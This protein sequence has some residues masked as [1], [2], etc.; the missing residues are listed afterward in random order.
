MTLYNPLPYIFFFSSGWR[1]R[2]IPRTWRETLSTV[3]LLA[4][5]FTF[6]SAN[7]RTCSVT[8]LTQPSVPCNSNVFLSERAPLYE[9]TCLTRRLHLH[10]RTQSPPRVFFFFFGFVFANQMGKWNAT[11]GFAA[12][13]PTYPF[14]HPFLPFD[15]WPLLWELSYLSVGAPEFWRHFLSWARSS[16]YFRDNYWHWLI[17]RHTPRSFCYV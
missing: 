16:P 12:F 14:P 4:L 8:A 5:A 17:H 3:G 9:T 10:A 7:H 2:G 13:I 11:N 1:A 15:L 6:R